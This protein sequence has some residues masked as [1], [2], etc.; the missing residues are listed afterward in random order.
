MKR[1]HSRYWYLVNRGKPPQ[2]AITA[3]ARE[4]AGFVWAVMQ[5]KRPQSS[6]NAA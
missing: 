4:L 2:V 6:K 5:E 1:L 3:V